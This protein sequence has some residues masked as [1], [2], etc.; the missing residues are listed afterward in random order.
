GRLM[1]R[2]QPTAVRDRPQ[3]DAYVP[4]AAV[5]D[6]PPG[7]VAA[8]QVGTRR[9]ALA[10]TGDRFIAFDHECPHAG[11]PLGDTRLH[12]GCLV[13]CPWHD[14]VFDVCEGAVRRGP[15]RKAPASYPVRVD[16]GTVHVALD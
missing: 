13:R 11:G 6:V 3:D 16:D 10:N 15:A 7:W 1:A 14:T 12:D 8:V 9:L 4:V 2:H 5:A